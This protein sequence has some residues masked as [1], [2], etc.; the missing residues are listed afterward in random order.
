MTNIELSFKDTSLL[1]YL[2]HQNL[3]RAN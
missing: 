1:C 2:V 3:M